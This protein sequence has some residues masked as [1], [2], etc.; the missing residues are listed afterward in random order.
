MNKWIEGKSRTSIQ[1]KA[2]IMS[3]GCGV[4]TPQPRLLQQKSGPKTADNPAFRS[5]S[6]IA[7]ICT[8]SRRMTC[9]DRSGPS[10]RSPAPQHYWYAMENRNKWPHAQKR[11]RKKRDNSISR[12]DFWVS[13]WDNGVWKAVIRAGKRSNTQTLGLPIIL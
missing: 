1:G 5:G 2:R 10:C 7:G 8:V 4:V 13:F 12:V 11:K 3:P 6:D 9:P